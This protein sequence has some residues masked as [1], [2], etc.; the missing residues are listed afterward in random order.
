M[1]FNNT[2]LIKALDNS[3]NEVYVFGND[4][5]FKYTNYG[6]QTNLGY[7]AE[8]LLTMTAF[9]IKPAYNL[10]KFNKLTKNLEKGLEDELVFETIHQRKN[11]T[12]YPVEVHLAYESEEKL[13]TAIILDITHRKHIEKE[14][15][16]KNTIVEQSTDAIITNDLRGVITF[17]NAA[18]QKLYGYSATEM[19][20][21]SIFKII[22]SALLKQEKQLQARLAKGE[23]IE[24]FETLRINKWQQS[25]N[26]SVSISPISFDGTVVSVANVSRDITKL[27]NAQ[28]ERDENL[29]KLEIAQKEGGFGIWGRNQE[30]HHIFW[31]AQ[32]YKIHE[33]EESEKIDQHSWMQL[34]HPDDRASVKRNINKGK[35]GTSRDLIYRII[36]PTG[37]VKYI[38]STGTLSDIVKDFDFIGI[39]YDITEVT[40]NKLDLY[41]TNKKLEDVL[42]ASAHGYW[43]YDIEK[44]TIEGSEMWWQIYGFEPQKHP[45]DASSWQNLIH[46]DDV[47]LVSSTFMKAIE[48]KEWFHSKSRRQRKDGE[49]IW[50]SIKGSVIKDKSGK[51][52][53]V[54]GTIAD[55]SEQKRQ[56]AQ[57]VESREMLQTVADSV[58]GLIMQLRNIAGV[59]AVEFINK[60]AREL[61]GLED[62]LV[63]KSPDILYN[64]MHRDDLVGLHASLEKS[65]QDFSKWKYEHRITLED[66][67][68]KWLNSHG[69][70]KRTNGDEIL[71]HFV[72]IDVTDKKEI[73]LK[74]KQLLFE[75]EEIIQQKNL[76]FKELH[77]RIK[78][79]LQLI[80]SLMYIKSIESDNKGLIDF[81]SDTTSRINSIAKIHEI[82][83]A[84]NALNEVNLELYIRD[85]VQTIIASYTNGEFNFDLEAEAI[86]LNIEQTMKIGLIINE[87]V[88]NIIKHAYVGIKKGKISLRLFIK[89]GLHLTVSDDGEGIETTNGIKAS[90]GM[91]MIDIMSKELNGTYTVDNTHGTAYYFKFNIKT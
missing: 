36:T 63:I 42:K 88:L 15:I 37:K 41:E 33:V 69:I 57:L 44:N 71:W 16:F 87:L 90:F 76:L 66:G 7:S 45:I 55:I 61:Y 60:G 83:L 2:H 11:K 32:M 56:E 48:N 65:L 89:N 58:P 27:K 51:V 80:N 70:P 86:T 79:N 14:L 35:I 39:N 40:L 30:H 38:H 49:Y 73:E 1:S 9:D 46:P 21:Q 22:P 31:D 67:T 85:L 59:S 24:H 43:T 74:N 84:N 47:D 4:F 53:K 54:S 78:N 82:L 50:V 75:L 77:H 19:I 34:I 6:A 12:T 25:I 52:A 20:G 8:V 26:V 5:L 68:L 3:I 29:L 91:R 64:K 62:N 72:S 18:A 10:A 13:F 28:L 23:Q 81:I 17:W